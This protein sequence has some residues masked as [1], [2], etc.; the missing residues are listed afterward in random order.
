MYGGERCYSAHF[1]SSANLSSTCLIIENSGGFV[2]DLEGVEIDPINYKSYII[3]IA[4]ANAQ[5][6]DDFLAMINPLL[7]AYGQ[8]EVSYHKEGLFLMLLA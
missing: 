2:T 1:S 7:E 4:I 6:R 5:A 8:E 3:A